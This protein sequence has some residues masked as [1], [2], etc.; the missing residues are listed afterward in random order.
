MPLFAV[1][2]FVQRRDYL[3]GAPNASITDAILNDLSTLK[4]QPVLDSIL[5]Y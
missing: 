1:G 2:A 4:V 3:I 5:E